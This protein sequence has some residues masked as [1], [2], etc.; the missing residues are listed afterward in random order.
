M[1]TI[2]ASYSIH[3]KIMTQYAKSTELS[4]INVNLM[5]GLQQAS[6]RESADEEHALFAF[7]V[8]Y[9]LIDMD[10]DSTSDDIAD[11]LSMVFKAEVHADVQNRIKL[12]DINANRSRRTGDVKLFL[13]NLEAI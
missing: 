2:S 3:K 11:F 10:A 6:T 5:I 1:K 7:L 4:D 13:S 12:W 8:I 9:S